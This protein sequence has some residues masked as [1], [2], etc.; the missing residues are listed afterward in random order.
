MMQ[1]DL[2]AGLSCRFLGG[3]DAVGG[4]GVGALAESS[5]SRAKKKQF[6]FLKNA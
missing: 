3:F 5:S 2:T 4:C 6:R 1:S